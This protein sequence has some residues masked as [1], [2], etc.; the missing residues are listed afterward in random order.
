[1]LVFSVSDGSLI[2]TFAKTQSCKEWIN[3]LEDILPTTHQRSMLSHTPCEPN[4]GRSFENLLALATPKVT[5]PESVEP[6]HV[7]IGDSF[8]SLQFDLRSTLQFKY[9]G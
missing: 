7:P 3:N 2:F 5:I 8:Q 1:V 9:R 4:R 6:A